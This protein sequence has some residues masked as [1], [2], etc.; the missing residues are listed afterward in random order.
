MRGMLWTIPNHIGFLDALADGLLARATPPLG[1]ACTLVLLPN[2]RAVRA[3]TEAFVRRCGSGGLLL[4]RMVPVGDL[5]DNDLDRLVAGS[6]TLAPAITPLTRR[7]EFARL[8]R[9]K[10]QAVQ[11]ARSAVE[12]LRLGTALADALDLLQAEEVP[13]ERLRDAIADADLAH[14]WKETLDFL[15]LIISAWPPERDRLGGADAGTRLA[16]AI[17][18]LIARWQALPPKGP[19]VAAGLLAG[20]PALARLLKAVLALPAGEVILPGLDIA[21]DEAAEARWE[22]IACAAACEE[23]PAAPDLEAHPQYL[24]KLTL[25]RLSRGRDEVQAWPHASPCDGPAARSEALY[26]AFAPASAGEGW[27]SL[28]EDASAAC[29]AFEDVR[30][31]EADTPAEEA[32]ALALAFRQW[33]EQPG[34]TAALVT[35]DRGLA[36]RVAAHCRRWGIMVDD[37]AGQPLTRT[38]PATLALAMVEAQASHFAPVA[39]LALL[40]HPLVRRGEDRLAWLDRVRQLDIALRGVRPAPGLDGVA[41]HLDLWVRERKGRDVTLADWWAQVSTLLEPLEQLGRTMDLPALSLALQALGTRLAGDALWA[42]PEGRALAERLEMLA[43]EGQVFGPFANDEAPALMMALLADIAIRPPWGG[44]PRLAIL[45]P[46]EAQLVRADLMILAGLNEGVWPA[47]PSPDPW[48]APAIRARL[49][50]PGQARELGLAAADFLRALGAP[51]VLLSRARRDAAGPLLPSRLLVRLDAHLAG[52]KGAQE[53][54]ARG[55]ARE[56]QLVSIARALDAA[57]EVQPAQRPRPAP[58]AALRPRD[59]SVTEV[60]TLIADPFAFHARRLLKLSPFDPLD[61]DPDAADRG[62]LMHKVLEDWVREGSFNPDRLTQLT[63]AMLLSAA[64]GFPLLGALWGPRA[65]RALAW[66]GA[67]IIARRAQGWQPLAAEAQGEMALRNGIKLKGRADRI[68]KRED[69]ALAIIDYKTGGVPKVEQVRAQL[70]NQLP[71]LA[72]MAAAG[73]FR[74]RARQLEPGSAAALE[75]WRLSGS[76]RCA[77]EIKPALGTRID[78]AELATHVAGTQAFVED[79]LETL[80]CTDMPFVAHRHPALAWGDYDHLARVQEWQHLRPEA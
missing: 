58:P 70:K 79:L 26:T 54:D 12:A 19:V 9:Q 31:L 50:L 47:P 44:H 20:T 72:A 29:A 36:R 24:L 55:L 69:G 34:R 30:L 17:D 13:P 51:R 74:D 39:L 23:P 46:L 10:L 28:P 75:Y 18:D 27:T 57:D 37:S 71:L 63:E 5:V 40:K 25:A 15:E 21:R 76:D 61:A 14:H 42:G 7:L 43:Q 53:E 56:T 45:G 65:R 62:E 66:A 8:V 3:L 73:A 22:A 11:P 1:L 32:Q 67:E 41:G 52:L 16:A 77:G 4:P 2:R 38:P 49:K 59:V 33:V 78:E 80:L 6:A 60:D 64:K 35:P 68:D 48:L